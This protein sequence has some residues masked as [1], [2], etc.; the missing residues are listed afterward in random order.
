MYVYLGWIESSCV[1][2]G[3]LGVC[4]NICINHVYIEFCP[5]A[6]I[7]AVLLGK[8][9][10]CLHIKKCLG[11][12]GGKK[13]MECAF[14]VKAV[15]VCVCVYVCFCVCGWVEG[16]CGCV[17]VS[18]SRSAS[19]SVSVPVSGLSVCAKAVC[20]CVCVCVYV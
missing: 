4:I 16:L 9:V 2:V 7:I 15:C 3:V 17:I 1:D 14:S 6:H 8:E 10:V 11:T 18:V 20:V 19:V 12:L 5:R 13:G